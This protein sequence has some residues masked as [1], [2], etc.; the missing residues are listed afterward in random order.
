MESLAVYMASD[1]RQTMARG[2]DLRTT[3]AGQPCSPM[4][5]DFTP[6]TEALLKGLGPRYGAEELVR[7]LKIYAY[8]TC[9]A[10]QS[11]HSSCQASMRWRLP[12][13]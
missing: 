3:P 12:P 8:A 2:E 4:F 13:V 5:Y 9:Y 1:R 7:Q 10:L 6:L 11:Y